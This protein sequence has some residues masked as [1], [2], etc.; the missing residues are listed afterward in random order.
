M[1]TRTYR[2]GALGSVLEVSMRSAF[3]VQILCKAAKGVTAAGSLI[4]LVAR[5]D[6]LMVTTEAQMRRSPRLFAIR[7]FLMATA[8]AGLAL[9]LSACGG[10]QHDDGKAPTVATTEG[11]VRG[12]VANGVM[13]FLGIPYAA[14]PV[15][16]LRWMPPAP[17]A[18]HA[19]LEAVAFGK[20]CAQ[21]NTLNVFAAPSYEEDCLYLNVF[22][23]VNAAS[24]GKRPVMVWLHGGGL[25][26]GESNDYDASKLARD[27][28]AVV[29]SINYRLNVFGFLAHPALDN[30]GHTFGNY[31]IMDQ[32]AA[33]RW[34]QNNIGA[35]GGDPKN[36]TL[37]GESSGGESTLANMIS[38]T[39]QGLFQ[40]AIVESGPVISPL[41][42][43]WDKDV[44]TAEDFGRRFATAVGCPDQRAACLRSLSV[45]DILTKSGDFQTT[46]TIV[47]GT[48][49]PVHFA[50]AFPSGQFN[51]V[52]LLI[53]TNRD[54][55]RWSN[56]VVELATGKPL[57]ASDYPTAIAG[58][59]GQAHAAQ[60]IKHYPLSSYGSPS[61]ALSAAQTD[62]GFSCPMRLMTKQVASFGV[63]TYAYEFNDRTAPTYMAPVS[64]PYGAAH[65]LE[66]QY[67]FPLYHGA[68][69]TPQPLNEQQKKLSDAMVSYW[70]TFAQY[71]NPNSD[72]AP[73][74]PAYADAP[75]SDNWQS[76]QLPKPVTTPTGDYAAEHQC[77]F[78]DTLN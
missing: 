78:W 22:A 10:G 54:E 69:G 19:L 46:Q 26:D 30:E 37:F 33:L 1:P 53:G 59:F 18:H 36:V 62:G 13:T 9:V 21:I 58:T 31:G 14:P 24:Q 2:L 70:T 39:A 55:W 63:A 34:V 43:G 45:R 52:S 32:Q 74:W 42:P 17:P 51:R 35:F 68:T 29:V 57:A 15:G 71:G 28:G 50:T 8:F 60:V 41:I 7:M 64:F 77:D 11:P 6:P 12:A 66:V 20:R 23:P 76:L 56:A 44:P 72:K 38:P 5:C 65:T 4:N 40:R 61:L 47:D 48:T 16:D 73:F 75:A 67:L 27:G 3:E 49:L 25:F